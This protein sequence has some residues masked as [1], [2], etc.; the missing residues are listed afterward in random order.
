MVFL[1]VIVVFTVND[2]HLLQFSF[3]FAQEDKIRSF[4]KSS[5]Y[6][7]DRRKTTFF[8]TDPLM[9]DSAATIRK[10]K[11]VTPCKICEEIE[12]ENEEKSA[13]VGDGVG[14][15]RFFFFF[16]RSFRKNKPIRKKR[17]ERIRSERTMLFY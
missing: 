11:L 9:V 2:D 13:D 10:R 5:K 14:C 7:K 1:S 6:L 8:T 17:N 3:P 15:C 4:S 12:V 16:F